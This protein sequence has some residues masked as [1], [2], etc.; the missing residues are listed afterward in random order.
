MVMLYQRTLRYL[1]DY[2]PPKQLVLAVAVA[3]PI[4]AVVQG[5]LLLQV[6]CQIDGLCNDF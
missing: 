3:T 1:W 4:A 2:R 5:A 6:S